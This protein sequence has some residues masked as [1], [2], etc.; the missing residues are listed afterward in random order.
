MPGWAILVGLM[1]AFSLQSISF[2]PTAL[3]EGM[4]DFMMHSGTDTSILGNDTLP[5]VT[6]TEL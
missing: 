2:S 3:R 5:E 1:R 4:L 6:Q